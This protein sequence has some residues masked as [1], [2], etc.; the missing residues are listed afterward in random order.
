MP[1]PFASLWSSLEDAL[2]TRQAG[3][4]PAAQA[5][6]IWLLGKTQAGKTAIIAALTGDSRAEIGRGYALHQ[7]RAPL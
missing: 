4:P 2:F 5:P 7:V 1:G 3:P 6:V